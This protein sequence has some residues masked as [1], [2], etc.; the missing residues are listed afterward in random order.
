MVR[1]T[2]M[3]VLETERMVLHERH[4]ENPLTTEGLVSAALDEGRSEARWMPRM[5]NLVTQVGGLA[6][7][8]GL[9][10]AQLAAA[11]RYRV[12][13][14]RALI[15]ATRAI[16]YEAVRVDT[17]AGGRDGVEDG[18]AARRELHFLR[19][20]IGPFNARTLD[21]VVCDEMSV[22]DLARSHGDAGGNG[23]LRARRRVRE[24]LDALV[25]SMARG[26]RRVRS[27]GVAADDWDVPVDDA[28]KCD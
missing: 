22:R 6:R 23:Q 7:M 8:K 4:I 18:A 17:S 19:R 9:N 26:D 10:D 28:S 1:K 27:E 3:D 20:R 21:Q 16:D 12:L 14:D 5:V 15:G 2:K 13:S 11:G 25:G 24:A